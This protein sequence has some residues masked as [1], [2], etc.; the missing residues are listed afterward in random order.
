MKFYLNL[1]GVASTLYILLTQGAIFT[2]LAIAFNLDE[3][4]IGLTASFPMIAQIFQILSPLVVEKFPRRR[5]LVNLFNL[6]SRLPWTFLLV[7]LAFEKRNPTF[8]V[9]IFAV[10]QI[11]GTLAG[12]AWTSLVRDLI[13]E[14]ERG[15]F[16]GRRNVYV[17]LT[18][19]VFF[20]VYSLLIDQLKDPL[21][22]QLAIAI[23]MFGTFLSFWA[24]LK[25]PEVPLK[26]SSASAEVKFVFQDRNFMKL[27][28]FYFVWNVVIAFTSPFFSYHLLKN[29]Q[30]PFSY[31]GFTG[32]LSSVVAMIFYFIWGR[33]SDNIGHKSVAMV[34]VFI[35]SFLPPMWFFMNTFTYRYLM[36]ADAV[37][38]GIG[39][40]A[41]NLS[42]P[43]L[44]ME[45][46]QSSSSAYFATY[47]ALGGVGGLIGALSG[48][49]IAKLLSDVHL[50]TSNL[51]IY[52]IQLMFLASG[53]L[54]AFT[55]RLLGRVRTR[56]YVPLRTLISAALFL[57]REGGLV[58][59]NGW[60]VY[61]VLRVVKKKL[62]E[63]EVEEEQWRVKRWW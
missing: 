16:F 8:F 9:L 7:F 17:S 50:G 27:C 45:V 34:G 54:R 60:N 19:L 26:S 36:I 51:P 42:F 52:G 56:R 25:V 4:L 46:A 59:S 13:P 11:F 41:I 39:W 61:E 5:T 12:N 3:F 20:Y 38:T 30:V 15:T 29:L 23:G 48:G 63:K 37:I 2:G 40:S 10:S 62:E 55:L 49:T 22:Y 44:P 18:S 43:T 31:I 35:V 47:A 6:L 24:M 53:L 14:S 21:G 33:L 57:S 32:V 1:E 58:R 28:L